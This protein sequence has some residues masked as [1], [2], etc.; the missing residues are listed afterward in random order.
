VNGYITVPGATICAHRLW[1][2]LWM[3]LGQAEDNPGWPGGNLPA[4]GGRRAGVHSGGLP[5][6]PYGTATVDA[7][8]CADLG[9]QR[10]SPISTDPMTTTF[11]YVIEI[12]STKQAARA[13]SRAAC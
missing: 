7:R 4:N 6:L 3:R 9:R 8:T 5:G 12:S 11:P 2:T 1:T 10:L 13:L